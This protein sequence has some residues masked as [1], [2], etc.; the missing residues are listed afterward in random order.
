MYTKQIFTA[1]V[2]PE[3]AP[4]CGNFEEWLLPML[5]TEK[6]VAI[7]EIGLDYHYDTPKD[8][9]MAVFRR[10]LAIAAE[11]GMPVVV[12]DRDAHKDCLD[13]VLEFPKVK[14]VFHSFSGSAETAAELVRAGWYISFSGVITFRNAEKAVKAAFAVP[15]DRILTETDCP[16]LAPHPFR[17]QRNDSLY[18]EFTVMKL[19]EIKGVTYEK[20]ESIT[21]E[22]AN[23]LFGIK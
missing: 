3:D 7:G 8:A 16:Y 2:H 18:M 12:H 19:A 22:N 5:S 10:H 13:A 15:L 21:T 6:C 4:S 1:G 17:G 11:H 9:Q 14:G 20:M 23:R